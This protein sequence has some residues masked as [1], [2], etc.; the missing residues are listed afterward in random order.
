MDKRSYELGREAFKVLKSQVEL[1]Q[2]GYINGY[3][4]ILD[5]QSSTNQLASTSSELAQK[6]TDIIS[7]MLEFETKINFPTLTNSKQYLSYGE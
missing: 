6:W 4:T 3:K 5:L 7:S 2:E 1:T